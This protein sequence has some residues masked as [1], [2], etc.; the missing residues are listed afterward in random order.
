MHVDTIIHQISKA[1]IAPKYL[2]KWFYNFLIYNNVPVGVADFIEG[3]APES[4]G[5]MHYLAEAKQAD[6]WY[7]QVVNV[8]SR[9]ISD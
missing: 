9:I 5:S 2:R 8:L 4:V 6:Y 1:G 3:R 7:E